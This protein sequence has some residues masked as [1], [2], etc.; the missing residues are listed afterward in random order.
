MLASKYSSAT[1]GI[2]RGFRDTFSA[3]HYLD[4]T[5]VKEIPCLRKSNSYSNHSYARVCPFYNYVKVN[6]F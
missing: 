1:Y 6:A 5:I 4:S 3:E 2:I